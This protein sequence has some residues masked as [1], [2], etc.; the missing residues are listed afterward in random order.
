M[1]VRQWPNKLGWDVGTPTDIEHDTYATVAQYCG[2]L[3]AAVPANDKV[4]V[5]K[6][7][8]RTI[9]RPRH[10]IMKFPLGTDPLMAVLACNLEGELQY[11]D[12]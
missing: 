10:R 8:G 6:A 3:I 5:N 1:I 11:D 4:E 7:M 9:R 2:G 12:R